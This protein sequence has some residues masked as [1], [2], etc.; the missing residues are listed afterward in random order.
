M[1]VLRIVLLISLVA[2][3]AECQ[4]NSPQDTSAVVPFVPPASCPVTV[5][6]ANS[7]IPPGSDQLDKKSF[8]LGNEKL[9]TVYRDEVWEWEPHA[10]GHEQEVQPLTVK[11]FLWSKDFDYR[12]EYPPELKVTGKRL[13]GYAPALL[14]LRP[15]N[16]F[17]GPAPA[18][19]SGVYVPTPGCWEITNEY[20]GEKLSF[21]VWVQPVKPGNQ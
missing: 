17:V 10:A 21:V 1:S 15:T 2:M 12:K 6:P 4:Q 13:D 5:R 11:I 18:M 3:T 8:V 9:W 16:A 7:F 14:T 20:K 19:L